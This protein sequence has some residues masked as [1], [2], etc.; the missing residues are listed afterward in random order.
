MA[1]GVVELPRNGRWRGGIRLD[2]TAR[3]VCVVVIVGVRVFDLRRE[4]R[5]GRCAMVTDRERIVLRETV[6]SRFVELVEEADHAAGH[7]EIRVVR[8]VGDGVA[9]AEEE[10]IE[11]HGVAVIE[12]ILRSQRAAAGQW[13]IRTAFASPQ[14]PE[15]E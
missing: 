2:Q 15:R 3:E 5:G 7:V 1:D 9:T 8:R 6:R 10:T 13:A 14:T 4:L 12:A 11:R